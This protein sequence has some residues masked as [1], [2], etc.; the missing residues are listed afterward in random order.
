MRF[1][2]ILGHKAVIGR[3]QEQIAR[4]RL[5]H[6][7]LFWGPDGVGKKT[8]ALAFAQTRLCRRE[9]GTGSRLPE[10]PE[11]CC[12]QTTPGPFF[13]PDACGRCRACELVEAG[14]HP[15]LHVV[16]KEL[17]A[18][19]KSGRV[20]A[21]FSID[22]VREEVIAKAGQRPMMGPK[23][24][25]ILDEAHLLQEA[26]ANAL[27]KVLEEP[28]PAS[29]LVLVAPTAEGFLPTVLSRVRQVAFSPL[30]RKLVTGYLRKHGGVD[31][32]AAEV[33]AAMT[34]GSIAA[35]LAWIAD[36]ALAVRDEL[37]AKLAALAPGNDLATADW[38]GRQIATWADAWRA[39][40]PEAGKL[41]IGRRA[42]MRMIAL[43]T[44]YYRDLLVLAAGGAERLV[45]NRDRLDALRA[46]AAGADVGMLQRCLLALAQADQRL[47]LN[48]NQDLAL[49]ALAAQLADP[50][51][52]RDESRAL[53][54]AVLA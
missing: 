45:A 42:A 39:A 14:T 21:S 53:K 22:L 51:S 52:V 4:D 36:G 15:D 9:K 25:F 10:R 35:G 19:Y 29:L 47:S 18:Q 24:I 11:G 5:A 16:V 31:A 13:P 3:L 50:A 54:R 44:W 43:V 1:A 40:T 27:L 33:A 2:D 28:P 6:V 26:A 46:A 37:F 38:L 7:Y 8:T 17:I 34:E 12:A 49:Q 20:G 30:P 48:A 23:R 32:A 41:E